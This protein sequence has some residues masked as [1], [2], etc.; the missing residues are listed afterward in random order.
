MSELVKV[1]V[2]VPENDADTLREA[3]GNADGGKLGNYAYCSFSAKGT[4]RFMPIQGAHPTIGS[5][6]KLVTVIEERIE[7]TC[8]RDKLTNIVQAI[9]N[10]HPYE[11]PA[12]D[13]Y[14]MLLEE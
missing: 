14:P 8:Q 3:I 10:N 5:V 9:R 1:V 13:I 2:T 7:I 4:G 6:G 11:E 12:I